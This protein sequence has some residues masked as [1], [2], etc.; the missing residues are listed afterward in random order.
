MDRGERRGEVVSAFCPGSRLAR[1]LS[2]G[3]DL[4]SKATFEDW[5]GLWEGTTQEVDWR[6]ARFRVSPT[7][8]VMR[9]FCQQA[10]SH[11]HV[12]QMACVQRGRA[13][14]NAFLRVH[15]CAFTCATTRVHA[16]VRTVATHL[17]RLCVLRVSPRQ[18]I[19]AA[20]AACCV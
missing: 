19:G 2:S 12:L 7:F 18:G 6:K 13:Y 8:Y 16:C 17:Q 4:R 3:Q 10:E 15:T 5:G 1:F 20:N 14:T 11:A 9:T